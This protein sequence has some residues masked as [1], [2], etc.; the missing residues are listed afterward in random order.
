MNK[1]I[2]TNFVYFQAG[3]AQKFEAHAMNSNDGEKVPFV[4]PTTLEGP[5]EVRQ[6]CVYLCLHNEHE[7]T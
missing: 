3:I 4:G 1:D 2:V 7:M 5:V 6:S